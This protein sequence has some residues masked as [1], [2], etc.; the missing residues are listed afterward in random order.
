M[1]MFRRT[2]H[3]DRGAVAVTVAVLL[4]VF[5]GLTAL[6]VDMG[7]LYTVKRQLQASAD[8][9]ALAGVRELLEG[10]DEVGVLAVAEEYAVYNAENPGDGL[11]MI[12]DEPLTEVGPNFVRVTVEK[13][14]PLF[15][16]RIFVPDNANIQATA[17]A[18]V[19]YITGMRNLVPLG[20]PILRAD[21]V[22]AWLDGAPDAG[23][24]LEK[25]EGGTW[26]GTLSV[27][28]LSQ[29]TSRKVN[30]TVYNEQ[31]YPIDIEGVSI[32]H[33]PGSGS[34]YDSLTTN[35][36]VVVNYPGIGADPASLSVS[37]V[38]TGQTTFRLNLPQGQSITRTGTDSYTVSI[39]SPQTTELRR[40]FDIDLWVGGNASGQPDLNDAA[41]VN[42]V[43]ST[44]PLK[45]LS[46]AQRFFAPGSPGTT[47][48]EVGLHDYEFGQVYHMKLDGDAEVGNF[49]PVVFDAPGA[50][51]YRDYLTNGYDGVINIGDILDTETGNMAGP[52]NQAMNTRLV[53]PEF[54]EWV[55]MGMPRNVPR[56]VYV[57]VVEQ[58]EPIQGKSRVIVVSFA[59]FYLEDPQGDYDISGRFVEYVMPSDF[60]SETPPDTGFYL[61]T[62]RLVPPQTEL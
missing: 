7:Y 29:G 20:L 56:L 9:G 52:T 11:F 62:Y 50:N 48:I 24:W 12:E 28:A 23:T 43:R 42:S 36:S 15:F 32:V 1:D 33:A 4:I 25:T 34:P 58:I 3:D 6:A 5:L 19:A 51:K 10:A 57:P 27:P 22:Y 35:S 40:V 44:Y 21:R 46:V 47:G 38:G 8:A 53:D 2:S 49:G 30:L 39:A 59:A 55:E 41:L 54:D 31:D 16:G 61:E 37:V 45:Y 17:E 18:R 60:Y 14:S 13:E 26:G